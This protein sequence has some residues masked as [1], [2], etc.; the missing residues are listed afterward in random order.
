[1]QTQGMASVTVSEINSS[2]LLSSCKDTN[3]N[4]PIRLQD[5]PSSM[6][7]SP[8]GSSSPIQNF[9]F[10]FPEILP[11]AGTN[12]II[13]PNL[14]DVIC[15]KEKKVQKHSGNDLLR[16]N[17]IEAVPPY[18]EMI[19]MTSKAGK[20]VLASRINRDIVSKMK[21]QHGSRFLKVTEKLSWKEIN[22]TQAREKVSHAMRTYVRV[23][24]ISRSVTNSNYCI[25]KKYMNGAADLVLSSS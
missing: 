23:H 25:N 15:K 19:A 4:R 18:L 22:D 16:N 11:K 9:T 5:D 2:W 6:F 8:S 10:R 1:M 14:A 12:N 13:E 3:F 20:K 21:Y 17:I 7:M 24:C